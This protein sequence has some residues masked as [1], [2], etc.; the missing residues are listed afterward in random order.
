MEGMG[1][2][3]MAAWLTRRPALVPVLVLG[4]VLIGVAAGPAASDQSWT[5]VPDADT[6]QSA[7][8][9]L[10]LLLAALGLVILLVGRRSVVSN[11]PRQRPTVLGALL[12]LVII[13]TLLVLLRISGLNG[14]ILPEDEEA[15]PPEPTETPEV[16]VDPAPAFQ[17]GD[18][19]GLLIVLAL[20]LAVLWWVRRSTGTPDRDSGSDEEVPVD[21]AER[22]DSAL[23]RAIGHLTDQ[24]DPRSAVLMAYHDLESTLDGLELDRRSAE[25]PTEHLTRALSTLSIADDRR[26]APILELAG[27][28][29]RA[30]FSDHE[31][32]ADEQQ[33][34]ATSLA[35]A[36]ST[37]TDRPR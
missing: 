6:A 36:R 3:S 10:V 9:V 28:Y 14:E 18:A 1:W 12:A 15:P 27:L 4:A 16:L 19:A 23:G 25:T 29:A 30:R 13:V 7:F 35:R 21:G 31:I 34:A 5:G 24:R 11:G 32:T 33:R 22:L 26:A 20:A 2:R 8:T 37:L 17:P